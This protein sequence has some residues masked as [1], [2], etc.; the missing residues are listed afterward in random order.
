MSGRLADTFKGL[1]PVGTK[2]HLQ[3]P[4]FIN[5]G[6]SIRLCTAPN[7]LSLHWPLFVG[8]SSPEN[9]PSRQYGTQYPNFP[10]GKC[11]VGVRAHTHT[12]ICC[13]VCVSEREGG[14]EIERLGQNRFYHAR[15]NKSRRNPIMG[16]LEYCIRT[17]EARHAKVTDARSPR[18]SSCSC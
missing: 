6:S 1:P 17:Q 14:E 8:S 5:V 13:A 2:H 4:F 15:L 7:C 9:L 10:E 12:R 16:S 18:H 3:I 11:H